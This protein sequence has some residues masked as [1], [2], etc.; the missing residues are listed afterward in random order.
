MG[1]DISIP[2]VR[3]QPGGYDVPLIDH[4]ESTLREDL[5]GYEAL[6]ACGQA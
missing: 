5:D 2:E 6:L 1:P 4:P 3:R